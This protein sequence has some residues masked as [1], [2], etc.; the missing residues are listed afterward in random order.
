MLNLRL[1]FYKIE[2]QSISVFFHRVIAPLVGQWMEENLF[3]VEGGAERVF[4]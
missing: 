3:C 2:L 4:L 1:F